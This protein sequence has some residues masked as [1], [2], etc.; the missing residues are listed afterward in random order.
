MKSKEFSKG[1]TELQVVH[2][3]KT[4]GFESKDYD[5]WMEF[6]DAKVKCLDKDAYIE[7]LISMNNLKSKSDLNGSHVLDAQ[8]NIYITP[9]PS[10]ENTS[11]QEGIDI[12][13]VMV[14][15]IERQYLV[16][17][18]EKDSN[19]DA[20]KAWEKLLA[21]NKERIDK[22]KRI[23]VISEMRKLGNNLR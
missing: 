2:A 5:N 4:T 14:F 7:Q 20:G 9:R 21:D 8:G 16:P 22:C 17:V 12:K 19:I 23:H 6:W 1:L 18:S 10:S 3:E 15:P 11:Q 13:D